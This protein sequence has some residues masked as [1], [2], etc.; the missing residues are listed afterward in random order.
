[1]KILYL[2]IALLLLQSSFALENSNVKKVYGNITVYSSQSYYTE[3][4][5]TTL[6]IAQYAELIS[7]HYNYSD[8]IYLRFFEGQSDTTNINVLFYNAEESSDVGMNIFFQGT[9]FNIQGCLNVIEKSITNHRNLK[10]VE[11]SINQLY[12]SP[13]SNIVAEI[14]HQK[15]Y[16]P[17]DTYKLEKV[18]KSYTYFYL[19]NEYHFIEINNNIETELVAVDKVIDFSAFYNLLIVFTR[20]NEVKVIRPK[21]PI[22]TLKLENT[23]SYYRPYQ[24]SYLGGNKLFI[25]FNSYSNENKHRIA[26][27]DLQKDIFVQDLDMILEK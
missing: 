15:I 20:T 4:V 16:R 24:I 19:D 18:N 25:E 7:K 11:K 8:K 6:I 27:Y 12:T 1:M 21:E 17:N 26:L 22:R 23:D 13:P 9:N 10:Q 3:G 5:N 14:L 2:I